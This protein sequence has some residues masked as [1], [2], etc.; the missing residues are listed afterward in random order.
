MNKGVNAE[1]KEGTSG[2]VS[3]MNILKKINYKNPRYLETA[4]KKK[5][6]EYNR[7]TTTE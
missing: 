4:K 2:L 6:K 3:L 7:T 5:K 1:Y